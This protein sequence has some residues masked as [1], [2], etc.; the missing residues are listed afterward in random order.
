[1]GRQ[2]GAWLFL[3]LALFVVLLPGGAAR[4]NTLWPSKLG[5]WP[6]GLGL[7]FLVAFLGTL[8]LGTK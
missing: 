3:F 5:F 1:M 8:L 4:H 6:T 2:D 7:L